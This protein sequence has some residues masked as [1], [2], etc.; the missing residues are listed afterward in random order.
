MVAAELFPGRLDQYK[1]RVMERAVQFR[2]RENHN[3]PH[4]ILRLL[5]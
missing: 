4:G 2:S 1:L 3:G 5:F